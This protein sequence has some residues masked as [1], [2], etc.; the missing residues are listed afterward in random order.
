MGIMFTF[1]IVLTIL[2]VAVDLITVS[3]RAG[4]RL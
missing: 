2:L 3:P 4:R 1:A